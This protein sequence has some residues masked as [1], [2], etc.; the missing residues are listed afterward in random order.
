MRNADYLEKAEGLRPVLI[1]EKIRIKGRDEVLQNGDEVIYDLG[2]HYVG[3]LS[4]SFSSIGRHFDAPFYFQI[5]FAEIKEEFD[6]DVDSYQGWIARSW[7][8]EERVHIDV[9]PCTYEFARRYAFRYL[10]IKVLSVSENYSV[11][12][13]SIDLKA[14]SSANDGRLT[15]PEFCKEDELLD[16][17]SLRTLHN[18]MQEVFEDGPKRDRRLWLGDLRLQALAN[19]ETYKN[20]DLV[21]RCLYLF[22]GTTLEDGKLSSNIFIEPE[23]ECDYQSMFDY[24]LFFI[25]VLYDYYENT[26]DLETLKD[27]EP[28]CVRQYEIL[29]NCFDE[30]DVIDLDKCDRVFIDWNFSLDKTASGQAV[31]IYALK[32]LVKI[33][34]I[35]K[36]DTKDLEEEIVRKQ[37]AAIKMF[38]ESKGL[39]VSGKERQ[40]S[41]ASQIWMIL[42]GVIDMNKAKEVLDR[43]EEHKD[44]IK[45]I[46][47]YAYHHY[48]QALIDAGE[49]EKAYGKMHD[50]WDGMIKKGCDTFW[51]IYDPKDPD[52]SPY[53][54]LAVHS[55]CHAWSCTP[56]YFLRKY[57]V[58][59][60]S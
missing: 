10:K 52:A 46:S 16:K 51:E 47:P 45:L 48:I 44:A 3:H 22:A 50:Y 21:K 19:Y 53:G 13:D 59:K 33:E 26:G 28:V 60:Q 37:A 55:F 11:K 2:N 23:V 1:E 40:I 34:K 29:K 54:G 4:I 41:Y 27:L 9:L 36:K 15:H 6:Q 31:Y 24:A 30:N 20:N 39:F 42:A 49:T 56:T 5:Q 58:K 14:V 18:C 25:N 32:D 7:I 35:L 43:L 38:D 57:F 12:I 8:Q 17:V